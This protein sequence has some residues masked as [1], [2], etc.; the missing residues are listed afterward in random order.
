MSY[1]EQSVSHSDIGYHPS[2]GEHMQSYADR[3]KSIQSQTRH[4]FTD[5]F[6]WWEHRGNKP[7]RICNT[8]DML[9]Y[10]IDTLVS[11]QQADKKASWKFE[12]DTNFDT[13]IV[14]RIKRAN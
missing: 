5:H 10:C 1:R 11:I 8:L 14:K 7:C 6:K 3:L 12:I 4:N 2:N 13:I 9:D